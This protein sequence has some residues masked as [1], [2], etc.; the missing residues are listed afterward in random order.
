MFDA[1]ID[2]GAQMVK[3]LLGSG[4]EKG[5]GSGEGGVAFEMVE[6]FAMVL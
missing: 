3:S 2:V 6:L 1:E 4:L 5:Q